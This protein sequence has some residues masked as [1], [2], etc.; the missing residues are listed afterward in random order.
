[1]ADFH[2]HTKSTCYNTENSKC[3]F[4]QWTLTLFSWSEYIWL[5]EKIIMRLFDFWSHA[6]KEKLIQDP[7]RLPKPMSTWGAAHKIRLG[8]LTFFSILLSPEQSL[9]EETSSK[10]SVTMHVTWSFSV[11]DLILSCWS[12]LTIPGM[13]E[14]AKKGPS[15]GGVRGKHSFEAWFMG[16]Q[17]EMNMRSFSVRGQRIMK[18]MKVRSARSQSNHFWRDSHRESKALLPLQNGRPALDW[19]FSQTP[20]PALQKAN[21]FLRFPVKKIFIP[22]CAGPHGFNGFY[23]HICWKESQWGALILGTL[24]FFS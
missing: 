6:L 16:E 24:F 23:C 14:M 22:N 5:Q 12:Q 17:S 18:T 19:C 7:E 10:W 11:G 13:E 2:P 21:C 3:E 1:M 4:H 20:P 8:F 15:E 9:R